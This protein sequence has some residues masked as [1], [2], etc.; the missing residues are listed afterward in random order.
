MR[1]IRENY[2]LNKENINKSFILNN[3]NL[4][5]NHLYIVIR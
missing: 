3:K 4:N 1:I 5:L 2:Y